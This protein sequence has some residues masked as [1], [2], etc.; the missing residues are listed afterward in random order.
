LEDGVRSLARAIVFREIK[1]ALRHESPQGFF[2]G[3][4]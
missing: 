3:F 1:K 2:S 4:F